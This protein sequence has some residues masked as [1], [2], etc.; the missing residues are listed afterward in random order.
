MISSKILNMASKSPTVAE[1]R[2]ACSQFA[3]GVSVVTAER[4]PGRVHGMTANSVTSVSLD[5]L[6]LLVCVDH[7]AQLLPM[8]R[9]KRHFGV[10]VLKEG[11]QAISR[12]FA[13]T[14]EDEA[15]EAKLGIRYRWTESGI[16]LLDDALVHIACTVID[17]DVAGDH[18]IFI[19]RVE[20]TEIFDG[21]PLI[22]FRGGYRKVVL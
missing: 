21:D 18:T 6:L 19:G 16:P 20:T 5:P 9:E 22:Y 2:L 11:Q 7:R 1:F 12:Y 13:Q 4:A 15:M 10:S 8:V 3:T 17:T 14:V